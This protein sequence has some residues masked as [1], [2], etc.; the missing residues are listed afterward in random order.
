MRL[1][2]KRAYEPS[3]AE[4]DFFEGVQQT[5]TSEPMIKTLLWIAVAAFPVS[6]ILLAF[7]RRS[8]G[9]AMLRQD[10]GSM[11]VVWLSTAVGLAL[12]IAVARV[13]AGRLPWPPLVSHLLALCLVLGGLALRWTAILTLGRLF[14]VD[15]AIHADHVVVETGPYRLVR[16]PSYTGLLIA[17]L[18]VGLSFASW[19]SV[20]ALLVPVTLGIVNRV[21]KEE[22]ALHASLG[23]PYAA[24]SARTKRFIPGLI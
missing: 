17:F 8:R 14:T 22:R 6:E 4:V 9:R 2:R 10:R 19:L 5:A 3:T 18:G 15:V 11:L 12:A 1:Y 21:A 20:L 13:P 23:A 24:Y 16:H 7:T